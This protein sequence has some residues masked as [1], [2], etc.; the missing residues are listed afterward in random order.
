MGLDLIPADLHARY[1]FAERD[2]ACAVLATDHQEQFEDIVALLRAFTLK[3]SY[4][5][6][7]GGS[8]GSVSKVIDGFLS[9]IKAPKKNSKPKPPKP[10][11]K[12]KEPLVPIGPIEGRGWA[13]RQFHIRITVDGVEVPIPTHE[14]D[15]FKALPGNAGGVGVEIQ[16]N[17][18]DPFYDRDL[19]NFRLLRNLGVLSVGVIITR[20][21]EL[22]AVFNKIGRGKSY[23]NSTTH[24]D[25]LSTRLN[26]GT[27]GGCP[28]LVVGLGLACYDPKS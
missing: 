19:T 24:W 16:W 9:G 12:P 11:K 26:N 1:T 25:K 18:K 14:I 27:A 10:G 8:R 5:N 6:D 15:N 21:S 13:P 28:V 4:F 17:N 20:L 7:P 3:R 22:Q 23:G 2:H